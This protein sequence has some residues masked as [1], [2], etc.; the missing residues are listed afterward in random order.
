MFRKMSS[1]HFQAYDPTWQVATVEA[2]NSPLYFISVVILFQLG[3]PDFRK[4]VK[5]FFAPNI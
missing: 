2:Q 3:G 4:R 1:F 5:S